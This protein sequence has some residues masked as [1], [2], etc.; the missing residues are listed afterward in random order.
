MRTVVTLAAT[1]VVDVAVALRAQR[2]E[3][4]CLQELLPLPVGAIV[5]REQRE[6]KLAQTS[7]FWSSIPTGTQE[8]TGTR[9]TDPSHPVAET[10]TDLST[11]FKK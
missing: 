7:L 5:V 2:R 9:P 8:L 3:W 4:Q 1:A 6:Q 11:A 10:S